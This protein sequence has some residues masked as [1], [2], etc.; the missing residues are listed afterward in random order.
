MDFTL[1]VFKYDNLEIHVENRCCEVK[2]LL[3]GDFFCRILWYW[4]CLASLACSLTSTKG[5][6]APNTQLFFFFLFVCLKY[7]EFHIAVLGL[8]AY[9][10][11]CNVQLSCHTMCIYFVTI[12]LVQF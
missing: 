3:C 6:N 9:V 4:Y 1:A 10:R 7:C 11:V 2:G 12:V 8:H 5:T